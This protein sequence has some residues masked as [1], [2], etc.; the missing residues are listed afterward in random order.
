MR[1]SLPRPTL[2]LLLAALHLAP[3]PAVAEEAQAP[4]GQHCMG[5]PRS[6]VLLSSTLV[7]QSEPMGLEEQLQLGACRPLLRTPGILFDHTNVQAG[8]IVY[9]SP[10]YAFPGAFVSIAP[11]SVLELR[12]EAAPFWVWPLGLD[13]AG[14]FPRGSADEQ[15]EDLPAEQAESA[16]GWT[17]TFTGTLQA[18][19]ELAPGLTLAAVDVL[20]W[21]FWDVGDAP[22]YY[23]PRYDFTLAREDWVGKNQA[24]LLVGHRFSPTLVVRAGVNDEW[25]GSARAGITQNILAAALTADVAGWPRRGDLL[26]PFLRV[27]GFT[28]HE[29]R[30]GLAV[31]GGVG[32]TWDVTP[33]R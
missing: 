11:L 24:F 7:A 5:E 2:A 18:E 13:G 1:P 22:Y 19:V 17:A 12:A 10:V 4:Q 26:Q 30:T 6:R 33:G 29:F 27:G 21:S 8:L 9:A 3:A 15:F 28:H 16:S 23:H 20:S 31:L 25:M 14:Y 32:V